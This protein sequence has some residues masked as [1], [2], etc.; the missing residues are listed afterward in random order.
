MVLLQSLPQGIIDDLLPGPVTLLLV[1]RPDAPL[2][3]ELNPGVGAIGESAHQM[4][5][6]YLTRRHQATCDISL[7]WGL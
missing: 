4:I 1:R 3:E 2:A 7:P 6:Y 5:V